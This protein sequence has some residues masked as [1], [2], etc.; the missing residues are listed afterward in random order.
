MDDD[1][2]YLYGDSNV[3][4]SVKADVQT[5]GESPTRKQ[6]GFPALSIFLYLNE[7]NGLKSHLPSLNWCDPQCHNRE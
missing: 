5:T 4:E 1:D 2:S 6:V 7:R 3:E